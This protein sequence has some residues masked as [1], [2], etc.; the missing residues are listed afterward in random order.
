M[1][2]TLIT[3]EELQAN[4]D[5]PNWLVADCRHLLTDP[6]RKKQ[7]Y[8]SS[9]IPGAIYV[10]VD[11]IL[12]NPIIPGVTGRHPL[13]SLA[14]AAERLGELGIGDR[15]Q[16]VAYDDQGGALAAARLWMILRWLGHERTAVLDGGWVKWKR[17]ERP[18]TSGV[19]TRPERH[20]TYQQERRIF[21][22]TS[23]VDRIRLDPNYRLVD[24]RLQERYTGENETIDP[25][26]GHIPG[27]INIPYA[28][29]IDE[30]GKFRSPKELREIYLER[31]GDTPASRVVFY[32]GSGITACHSHLA[33]LHAGLGES[34]VY[35]GSWS[36]WI[37]DR[38][39]PVKTGSSSV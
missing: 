2:T 13:P 6:E 26:P 1:H 23:D 10:P 27:A 33:L 30:S 14:E 19:E 37:A 38:S 4:L 18:V 5:N 11:K 9:H 25:I 7:E 12:A 29:N 24:V 35:A 28:T 20:L 21:I 34:K 32:C 39:K 17:E 36:E 22:S 8:L 15:T 16:V 31:L 3:T